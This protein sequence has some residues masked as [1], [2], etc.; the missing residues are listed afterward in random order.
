MYFESGDLNDTY[1]D[2]RNEVQSSVYTWMLRMFVLVEETHECFCVHV[3]CMTPQEEAHE[4][5][6]FLTASF[7]FKTY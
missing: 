4:C 3:C 2:N 1:T 6:K 7:Q 5:Y